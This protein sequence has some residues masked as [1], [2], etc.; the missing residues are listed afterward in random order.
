MA[1][2]IIG[3]TG[4]IGN[5]L[6]RFLVSKNEKVR[7]LARRVDHNLKDID[8]DYVVCNLFNKEDLKKNIHEK[9]IVINLMAIIDIK[10]KLKEETMHVNYEGCVLI[11]DVC[12]ENKV[13]KYIYCST[14]D[15][16]YK[17]DSTSTIVEPDYIDC[18][19]FKNNYP[20]TKG[21]ATNYVIDKMKEKTDTLIS[22]VYPSAVI[23][24]NDYKPSMIGKVVLDAINGKMEFGVKGG[25][26]FIDVDDVVSAIYS[27]SS[28]DISD[29]F[30]LSGHNVSVI[31]L[32]QMINKELNVK[33]K[34]VKIPMWVVRMACPFV[35]YLSKFTIETI[36]ENHN[37][38][39]SKA[40]QCLN[41]HLT[42]IEE[43]IKKTVQWFKENNQK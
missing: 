12:I 16:I 31:E 36:L 9:D 43:T 21:L 23:G 4:H 5:N 25:Y 34:I 26:N 37:Y 20:Y 17:P 2:V 8:I 10:N 6:V 13:S 19:K 3:A 38:D 40:K 24:I 18:S 22:I 11:T 30:I 41:W 1:Y 42:P 7:V 28:S 33:R 39:S 27:I 32:Y 14:V 29:T 15:A 35:P